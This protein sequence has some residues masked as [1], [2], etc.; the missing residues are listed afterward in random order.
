MLRSLWKLQWKQF[1][2]RMKKGNGKKDLRRMAGF[3]DAVLCGVHGN[4]DVCGVRRA[5]SVVRNGAYMAVFR[6]GGT[7]ALR[8][9]CWAAFL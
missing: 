6:H 3:S 9:P 8:F 4:F 5:C 7:M 1:A 2:A